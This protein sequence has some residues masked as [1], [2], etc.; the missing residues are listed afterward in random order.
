MGIVIKQSIRSSL[1]AYVG[2]AIGAVNF[3]FIFPKFLSVDQVGLLRV[4]PSAA[5][6]M[7][8]FAQLGLAPGIIKFLPSYKSGS[9]E[10][11]E[12]LGFT[13]ISALVGYGILLSATYFFKD[14]I[15]DYYGQKS[16]LFVE[17]FQISLIVALF[18]L[19]IQMSEA[20]SRSL[21]KSIAPILIR[22]VILRLMTT[23]TVLLYGFSIIQFDD[24]IN[25]FVLL[26]GIT[27]LLHIGYFISLKA[28][29]IRLKFNHLRKTELTR[30]LK[31]GLFTL[32]GASGTQIVLQ[33]D[34]LMV[35]G[36]K[37]LDATGIYTIAFFIGTIIE[38]P[39]RSI[40]QITTPL[41]ARAFQNGNM[42]EVAQYYKQTS[43]NQLVIGGLLLLGVWANLESIYMIMPNS[44]VYEAGFN[45][46]L[47]IGL[48]KLTDMLFGVNGEIIVL[49]KYYRFNVVT[50]AILAIAIIIGNLILI[51]NYGIEG[52]AAASL[53]AMLLFNL[54]KF[55]FV[56]VKFKIQPFS[57][58]TIKFLGIVAIVILLN[59]GIPRI[60]NVY[61]DVVVRSFSIT[62]VLL[63]LTYF[64]KV[65][66]EING[67]INR[68]IKK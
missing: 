35:A 21:L 61:L 45:V 30:V 37:G 66:E 46:V 12:F 24:F 11:K 51:P 22:D 48:G 59:L 4:I 62:T 40:T 26:Y 19:F 18:L 42:K 9:I 6:L 7:A 55:F 15:L 25:L 13:V 16:P 54:I 10:R 1:L 57:I 64:M 5:F 50:V 28:A 2:F 27:L 20:Y 65:S 63:L 53:A 68:V 52:A 33:I 49:S 3:L 34:S 29:S 47:L 44:E 58:N 23:V 43:I 67:I 17:Y 41:M 60:Y 8:T 38:I 39:K 14:Q 36:I 56:F 32:I 31:Y